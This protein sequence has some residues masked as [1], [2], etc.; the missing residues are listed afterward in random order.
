[1][2][3]FRNGDKAAGESH[4]VYYNNQTNHFAVLSFL[5][6]SRNDTNNEARFVKTN[7]KTVDQWKKYFD[8]AQELKNKNNSNTINLILNL[9]MG[10]NVNDFWRYEGSLST[11]PCTENVI[12]TIFK[13]RIFI[14]D[15]QFETFR[16]DLFFQ[17]Y[18]GPQSLYNRIVYRSFP[19]K[20]LSP[21]PDQNWCSNKLSKPESFFY[22]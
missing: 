8:A 18:R 12:W 6:E 16:D 10:N 1:M 7:I 4:F 19:D 9:L 20:I 2:Y 22:L 14:L 11:P 5:M 13:Q 15:Y 17:S 21:I 3:Q